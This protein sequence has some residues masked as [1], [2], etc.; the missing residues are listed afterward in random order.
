MCGRYSQSQEKAVL[1]GRFNFPDE[2]PPLARRYNQAPGQD[3][4]VV[5]S[6]PKGRRL[7][8]MRWGLVPS[9]ARDA[10]IGNRLINAQAET[11][12][13][14]P[15]FR[16]A[17]R[18][19]RCLV[20]ADGYYEWAKGRGGKQPMRFV[21]KDRGSFAFAGLWE[22]WAP[23]RKEATEAV[24]TFTVITT[25]P[26]QLAAEVHDRMPAI[27]RP[28]DEEVWLAGRPDLAAKA[29]GPYPA[30]EMECYPVSTRVNSPAN[31][32]DD[33]IEPVATQ[34]G[35]FDHGVFA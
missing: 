17:F 19:R 27:L 7:V 20:L 8:M 30:E 9:W 33:L 14:K 31:E 25:R 24:C 2:G 18:S 28:R 34:A 13:E 29:L 3:A 1:A 35:L 32:G 22:S 11:L 15:A 5:I 23:R 4:G 26:N 10:K 21:L 6:L 12:T 16:S